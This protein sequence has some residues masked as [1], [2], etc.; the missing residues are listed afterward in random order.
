MHRAG[1]EGPGCLKSDKDKHCSS[2][3]VVGSKQTHRKRDEIVCG[4][5]GGVGAGEMGEDGPDLDF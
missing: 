2:H 1:L 4:S 3:F 5:R